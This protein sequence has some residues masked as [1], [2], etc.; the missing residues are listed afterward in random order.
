[1][2]G[3]CA[4]S[5]E[6]GRDAGLYASQAKWYIEARRCSLVLMLTNAN[7]KGRSLLIVT[8]FALNLEFAHCQAPKDVEGWR[9]A[10]WG[11]TE[12][13]VLEAF[14]G[15]AVALG[16]DQQTRGSKV[17]AA[18]AIQK[19]DVEGLALIARFQFD[20]VTNNLEWVTLEPVD[21]KPYPTRA[22]F[23]RLEPL[24]IAKY[25]Q[26][27]HR[28]GPD[29]VQK[30][31]GKSASITWSFPTTTVELS[32]SDANTVDMKK[33]DACTVSYMARHENKL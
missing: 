31:W 27:T 24:L 26:P 9:E 2:V 21:A 17:H 23:E 25:G 11:M 20:N 32:Y 13:Q 3:E 28:T 18:I 8:L 10:K 19:L 15:E 6:Q 7:A 1:M 22:Y 5:G 14:R 33:F 12:A 29:E 16:K 30:P 4:V